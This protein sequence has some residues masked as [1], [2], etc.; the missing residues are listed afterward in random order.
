ITLAAVAGGQSGKGTSGVRSAALPADINADSLN[1]LPV[2]KREQMD[3][4]GKQVYDHV[5]GGA[6]K[7]ASPTGPA[8]IEL[9][10]PGAAEPLRTLNEYLRRQGNLLGNP[11]TELAIL[12]AA[13]EG[14]SQYVWSA[15]EPAALKAGVAQPVIDVVKYNRDVAGAG[16]KETVVIRM[17]RQLLREHK[18]DSPT[19]AKA[20]KLFGTQGTVEL[21][22][23][24]GDYTLNGLLLDALDQHLPPDRKP[25]LPSR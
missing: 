21:V 9:Y 2:V 7:I 11:I 6:G 24:M 1:R 12:V 10:S 5:A 20:V 18:L 19:F 8:S 13:R 15:H 14:D 22:T 17:G 23:L 16:E 25:L 4:K 3:E